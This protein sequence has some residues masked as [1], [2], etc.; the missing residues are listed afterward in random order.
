MTS[1][2]KQASALL[3]GLSIAAFFVLEN[4]QV[5]RFYDCDYNAYIEKVKAFIPKGS[6]VLASS[7][8]WF[9]LREDYQLVPSELLFY[10]DILK[11]RKIETDYFKGS[12]RDWAEIE[13]IQY[14][15][16]DD[17]ARN[18]C[19]TDSLCTDEMSGDLQGDMIKSDF[20]SSSLYLKKKCPWELLTWIHKIRPYGW[21]KQT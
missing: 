15:V 5:L 1:N 19:L 20:Y 2:Y 17:E 18:G 12:V 10:R 11:D 9:G 21:R 13:G 4:I 8:Y 14:I 7:N 16:Y 3:L 6:V